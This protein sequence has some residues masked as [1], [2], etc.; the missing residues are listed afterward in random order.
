MIFS[1]HWLI[2]IEAFGVVVGLLIVAA[3]IQEGR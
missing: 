1:S 2:F 3:V